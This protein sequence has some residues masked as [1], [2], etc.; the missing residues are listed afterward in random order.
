MNRF[1]LELFFLQLSNSESTQQQMGF[2]NKQLLL[3]GEAHKLSMQELQ[4]AGSDNTKVC[5]STDE[6][7]SF[8]EESIFNQ[9]Q[10]F[11]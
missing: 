2:L 9:T 11:F 10:A 7:G 6:R 1:I 4:N 3:L 8:W 5:T